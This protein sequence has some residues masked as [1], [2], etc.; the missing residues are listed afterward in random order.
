MGTSN[1]Q[2]MQKV[3]IHGLPVFWDVFKP[4]GEGGAPPP[5]FPWG[6][7]PPTV[8]GVKIRKRI[9]NPRAVVFLS[10]RRLPT[11]RCGEKLWKRMENPPAVDFLSNRR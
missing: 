1:T 4:W 3:I 5:Y 10:N 2:K 9:E 11:G 6:A 8:E 7:F